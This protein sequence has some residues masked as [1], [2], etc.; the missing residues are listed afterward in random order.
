MLPEPADRPTLGAAEVAAHYGI[1]V[2]LARQLGRRWI[3]TG[4]A[5]GI[6]AL[7]FGRLLK[8]PTAAV[9]R[10]LGV[11][12]TTTNGDH[13]HRDPAPGPQRP[14]A[15][16]ITQRAYEG[17]IPG[18]NTAPPTRIQPSDRRE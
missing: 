12:P 4:G 9:R 1:G 16:P 6:P 14:G 17:V 3:A 13:P 2:T 15:D 8:F 7:P 18:D 5:E 10:H 11:D